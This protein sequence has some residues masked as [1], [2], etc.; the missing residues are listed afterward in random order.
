MK[1]KPWTGE[2]SD[3][4]SALH[5]IM[6][7]FESFVSFKSHLLP[8]YTPKEIK[9]H[10]QNETNNHENNDKYENYHIDEE[11]IH[12]DSIPKAS[13]DNLLMNNDGVPLFFRSNE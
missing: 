1:Y 5:N 3:C 6:K 12:S 7:E 13:E 11:S 8:R 10:D 2:P 4:W 9:S